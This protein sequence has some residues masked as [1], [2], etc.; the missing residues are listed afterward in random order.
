MAEPGKATESPRSK[1]GKK[2]SKEGKE[3]KDLTVTIQRDEKH[4]NKKRGTKDASKDALSKSTGSNSSL[5][6]LFDDL[7]LDGDLWLLLPP[8]ARAHPPSKSIVNID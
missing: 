7:K 6:K 3:S 2:E 4:R 1:E 8:K 5:K